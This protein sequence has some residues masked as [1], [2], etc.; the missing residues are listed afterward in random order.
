MATRVIDDS[1]LQSIA[2]AIQGK[3]GGGQ[4]TVDEMPERIQ[5]LPSDLISELKNVTDNQIKMLVYIDDDVANCYVNY[6]QTIANDVEVD[7]GDGTPIDTSPSTGGSRVNCAAIPHTYSKRGYLII[8]LSAHE[9][10][11]KL[12]S[13]NG[14]LSFGGANGNVNGNQFPNNNYRLNVVGLSF[15]N[16]TTMSVDSAVGLNRVIAYN[17]DFWFA[18]CYAIEITVRDGAQNFPAINYNNMRHV[19]IPNTVTNFGADV[20][21]NCPNLNLI[22]FRSWSLENINSAIFNGQFLAGSGR[23]ANSLGHPIL[24]FSTQEIAEAAKQKTNLAVYADWITYE[25]AN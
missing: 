14:F 20:M 21:T 16:N 2:V 25:G 13:S 3:D 4:M 11:I 9:S 6:V 15:G 17:I 24:L 12:I 1:K 18:L 22:D 10:N 5:A 23:S 7:W 19:L 8:T